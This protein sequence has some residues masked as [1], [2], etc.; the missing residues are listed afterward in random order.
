MR[1]ALKLL[2]MGVITAMAASNISR[3]GFAKNAS[4]CH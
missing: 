3:G 2:V 1:R 4:D